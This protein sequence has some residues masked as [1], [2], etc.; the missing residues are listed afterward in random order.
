MKRTILFVFLIIACSLV[1]TNKY[2][3]HITSVRTG[4]PM[5]KVVSEGNT[6]AVQIETNNL[7][8]TLPFSTNGT[9]GNLIISRQQGAILPMDNQQVANAWAEALALRNGGY[10]FAVL[11]DTLKKEEYEKYKEMN[12]VIGGSS[13]WVVSYTVNEVNKIDN[14]AYE[15]EINY[16][17]MDSTRAK[18]D[19]HE[20]IIIKWYGQVWFVAKHENYNYMPDVT[21]SNAPKF[22]EVQNRM[23]NTLASKDKEGTVALWAEALIQRNGAFR[24]AVLNNDI[25]KQEEEA[26]REMNWVIGVSSPWVVSY[27]FYEKK[28]IDDTTYEYE[29]DYLM[30]DSTKAKYDSRESIIVKQY[31]QSS[32]L[33]TKHDNQEY[34]TDGTRS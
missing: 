18:Y 13:P 33:V 22:S 32:W 23:G 12:W 3:L 4:A 14:T 26:Y 5:T 8:A 20:I 1:I 29:I 27:T 15:Y 21:E 6:H 24:F 11:N 19:S 28:R 9:S 30:T 17:M 7:N 31:W 34:I 16:L 10:R 25:K 2:L